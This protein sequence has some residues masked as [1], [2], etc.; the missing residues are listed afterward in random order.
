MADPAL[1][2]RIVN[3]LVE[4]PPEAL[5]QQ[6]SNQVSWKIDI[7]SEMLPLDAAGDIPLTAHARAR[8]PREGWDLMVCLTD[9]PGSVDEPVVGD[10]STTQGAAQM[11]L[12]AMGLRLRRNVRNTVVRLVGDMAPQRLGT[13][14]AARDAQQRSRARCAGRYRPSG[15]SP[16]A[17]KASTRSWCW[18]GPGE[19]PGCCSA[20]SA[21]T[22]R[23][24]WC[25]VCPA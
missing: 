24:G 18:S 5:G 13:D 23:G 25:R 22:A 10:F 2:T 8:M 6:V 12:P 4:E 20:W 16:R 21:R 3:E 17:T 15:T 1:S 14:H 11:S 19:R 7:S 9:L